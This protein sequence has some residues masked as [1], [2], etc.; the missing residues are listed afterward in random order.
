MEDGLIGSAM[1][2]LSVLAITGLKDR[3]FFLLVDCLLEQ[4]YDNGPH[5]STI[6]FAS[7]KPIPD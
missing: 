7:E 3:L 2:F 5:P 6:T 4:G 1:S